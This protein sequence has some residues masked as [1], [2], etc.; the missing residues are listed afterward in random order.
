MALLADYESDLLVRKLM[1]LGNKQRIAEALRTGIIN[2][3]DSEVG[4]A[5]GVNLRVL[6]LIR[7]GD[8]QRI[9]EAL[10]TGII[11]GSDNKV[12]VVVQWTKFGAV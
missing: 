10:R 5:S 7:L 6:K 11:S 1:R 8:K 9:A 3:S 12:R 4:C 2:S